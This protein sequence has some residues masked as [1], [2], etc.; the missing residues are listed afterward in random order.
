MSP[1]ERRFRVVRCAPG[2]D[3]AAWVRALRGFDPA[4]ADTLKR[5][6]DTAVYRATILG[7]EVVLKWCGLRGPGDRL[8]A[9]VGGSRADRHWRG[10]R[11]LLDHGIRTGRPLVMLRERGRP[12]GVWLILEYLPGKS[13]LQHLADGDLT[14]RQEH[15]IAA[16]LG[17]IAGTIDRHGR[18]N[19]DPKPSNHIVLRAEGAEVQ[20]GVI[21]CSAIRP[22]RPG[23]LARMLAALVIEPLGC[24]C[25][26]RRALMMRAVMACGAAARDALWRQA[27]AIVEAHGDPTP[28]VNPLAG[29]TRP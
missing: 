12:P 5:D 7:R 13:V 23:T 27:R 15:R 4:P 26:P 18:Y 11:W 21:D 1:G 6:G 19:R 8:K 9:L 29:P 28:R 22:R 10:A 14:P 24:G 17:R 20:V 2:E 3:A 16:E 25:P